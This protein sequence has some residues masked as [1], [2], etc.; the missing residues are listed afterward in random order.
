MGG[1]G[2]TSTV[3]IVSRSMQEGSSASSQWS[4]MG[5][6]SGK[7]SSPSHSSCAECGL[8]YGLV[9]TTAQVQQAQAACKQDS[10]ESVP[11]GPTSSDTH[12]HHHHKSRF[13]QTHRLAHSNADTA[14][15]EQMVAGWELTSSSSESSQIPESMSLILA[16]DL[17]GAKTASSGPVEC[18]AKGAAGC[19]PRA[20]G[21]HEGLTHRA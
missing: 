4:M 21:S 13:K 5:G 6:W 3:L 8:C 2:R 1:A 7:I 12:T 11:P 9:E 20:F 16:A 10:V 15:E 19:T 17:R 14:A 18:G